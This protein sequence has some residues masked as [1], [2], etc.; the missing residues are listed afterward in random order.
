MEQLFIMEYGVKRTAEKINCDYCNNEFIRRIGR[1]TRFCSHKCSTKALQNKVEIICSNCGCKS[2]KK[3]SQI[4]R[5][6]HGYYFCTKKCKDF[7]QSL[8]GNVEAI[9]PSHYGTS[10]GLYLYRS[11]CKEELLK[12]CKC[13]EKRPYLLVV[14]HID[15]NRENNKKDNLEVVC[16]NCHMLRHLKKLNGIW[17]YSPCYLTPREQIQELESGSNVMVTDLICTQVEGVR[18]P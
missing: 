13:G 7:A 14:H 3:P 15:G 4:K 10:N 18:F 8:K 16:G 2:F 5:A 6:K 17:V 11:I 12:G 1:K 9:R